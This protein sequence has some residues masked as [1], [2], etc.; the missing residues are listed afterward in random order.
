MVSRQRAPLASCPR[1]RRE[2][3]DRHGPH[4]RRRVGKPLLD[5]LRKVRL[6]AVADRDQDVAH[7]PIASGALDRRAG[8]A[9]PEAGIIQLDELR[10][11]RRAQ[12]V[13]RLQLGLA[14][15]AGEL[16]PRADRETVVA[17]VDAI[18]HR[19]AEL[20]RYVPLVLDREVRDAA[21]GV[22]LVRRGERVGR[23][24]VQAGAAAAAVIDLRRIGRK[25][26]VGED[27]AEEQPGAE[28]ARYEIGV[29]ALPADACLLG[30]RLLQYRRRVDEHLDLGPEAAVHPAGQLL[31]TPLDQ[32]V[33]VAVAGV[34]RDGRALTSP[35]G[36]ERIFVRTIVE[37]DD[38]HRSRLRPEGAWALAALRIARE[39][40]HVAVPTQ[41][42]IATI[43]ALPVAWQIGRGETDGVETKCPRALANRTAGVCGT[44]RRRT[45][46]C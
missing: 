11:P 35:E 7:E 6:A 34:N 31:E 27:L 20:P 14:G 28:A 8:K 42:E 25:R 23:A 29:L 17:A 39:P 18:A 40:I 22:E 32:V 3:P 43:G 2:R 15:R 19:G 38:D 9:P 37:P 36:R 1:N 12:I 24:D 44:C 4:Q 5:Q 46:R 30:K 21:P 33:V 16:V 45:A 10:E 13:T 26:E 41:G